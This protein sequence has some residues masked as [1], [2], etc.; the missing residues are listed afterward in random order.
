MT[1]E[2]VPIPAPTLPS[3]GAGADD[4][5]VSFYGT[6]GSVSLTRLGD[7]LHT[8]AVT[9]PHTD[10]AAA[11]LTC[12]EAESIAM[13]LGASGYP[14]QAAEFIRLHAYGDNEGDDDHH[15]LYHEVNPEMHGT[16]CDHCSYDDSDDEI[17]RRK[18][19]T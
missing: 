16:E 4:Q 15:D 9:M 17:E 8:L 2:Q 3:G 18:E 5:L 1:D 19:S 14:L 13:V 6:P 12:D 10:D 7:A 11:S